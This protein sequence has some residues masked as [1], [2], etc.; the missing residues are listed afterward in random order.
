[1]Q[2]D[3][4]K[5]IQ[6]WKWFRTVAEELSK[7]S[8]DNRLIE[9]LDDYVYSIGQELEWEMG[10]VGSA[11]EVREGVTSYLAISPCLNEDLL[12]K[13]QEII[14]LAPEYKGWAFFPAKPAKGWTGNW[15]MLNEF[16]RMISVDANEWKYTLYQFEDKTYDMDIWVNNIDGN[17]HTQYIAVD[18][19]I[20]NLLGEEKFMKQIKNIKIVN[21]SD[22]NGQ[23]KW[24]LLKNLEKHLNRQEA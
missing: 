19:V 18:I 11:T 14:A 5:T 16:D 23:D 10:P 6:F 12:S 7:P 4:D 24:T 21:D 15:D 13:T 9:Q 3:Y 22:L 8:D 1:M 2:I 20:T 17:L